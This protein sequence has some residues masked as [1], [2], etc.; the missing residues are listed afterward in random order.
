MKCV[1]QVM[2]GI[3]VLLLACSAQAKDVH[4]VM[5]TVAAPVVAAPE[6][7][8]VAKTGLPQL[9][10]SLYPSQVFW[11]II[12]FAVL[13]LLMSRVALPAVQKTQ[14][15]RHRVVQTDL[16][17]ATKASEQAKAM[18]ATYEKALV[19]A[20]AQ[21][22]VTIGDIAAAAAKESAAQQA[23]KQQELNQ[24]ITAAEAKIAAAGQA[25]MKDVQVA[26]HDLASVIV[27]KISG[28]RAGAAR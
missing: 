24:R 10:P 2:I 9:D 5:K 18:Q 11:L 4:K 15:N 7:H 21:A 19:D 12:S 3:I 22:Q 28:L 13:Y 8:E 14:A 6:V 23:T 27:E 26:A 16:D 20:R 17:A 25:A 1:Q